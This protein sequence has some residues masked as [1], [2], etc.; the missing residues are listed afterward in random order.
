MHLAQVGLKNKSSTQLPET[1]HYSRTPLNS[2][3]GGVHHFEFYEDVEN[4]LPT[5]SCSL[6]S[7]RCHSQTK[8]GARCSRKSV[9]GTPYCW[10]HLLSN[11]HLRLLPSTV[12]NAGKGVFVLNKQKPLGDIIIRNDDV[13]CPYGGELIDEATLNHR[14]G[15]KTAPYAIWLSQSRYRDAACARGIGSM[16]NHDSRRA[17]VVFAVNHRAKTVSI[18]AKR[19]LRN[20]EELFVSYGRNYRFNEG[21]RY[22]TIPR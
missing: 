2:M 15:D 21:T 10:S 22:A 11:H 12:P 3:H 20:G 13:V 8:L 14:Y 5:F 4:R 7:E 1:I 9:I 17:N 18:K 19:N 16:I 6:Q